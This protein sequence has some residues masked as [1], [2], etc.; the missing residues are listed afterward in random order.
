M[1]KQ[2]LTPHTPQPP[3]RCPR[4]TCSSQSMSSCPAA[5]CAYAAA[6]GHLLGVKH[7]AVLTHPSALVWVSSTLHL[8]FFTKAP[9]SPN[10]LQFSPPLIVSN[11]C[12]SHFSLHL[13]FPKLM[14]LHSL[15]LLGPTEGQ[16]GRKILTGIP[17]VLTQWHK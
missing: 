5:V 10:S 12:F 2:S 14:I 8:L 15:S 11:F 1:N 16:K 3:S 13:S 17:N 6:A 7:T 4:A 9:S